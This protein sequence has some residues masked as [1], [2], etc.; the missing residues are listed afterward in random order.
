[1]SVSDLPTRPRVLV[2]DDEPPVLETTAAILSDQFDVVTAGGAHQ[3]L[4]LLYSN[5][6]DVLCTDFQMPG[7]DGVE[8]IRRTTTMPG[9]ISS[10]LVTGFR[11]FMER[12]SSNPSNLFL[13]LMKPYAPQK[14]I[15]LV[16]QAAHFSQFQRTMA[17]S[18]LTPGPTK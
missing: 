3:A 13:V 8:L 12:N 17:D 11:E 6:F 14:L 10:L 18:K 5:H 4:A 2:V 7:I 9:F 15:D 1:M 16:A